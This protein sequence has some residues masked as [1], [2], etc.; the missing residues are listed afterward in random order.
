MAAMD[1]LDDIPRHWAA[2]RGDAI[3][4]RDEAGPRTWAALDDARESLATQIADLGVR[5]GDR[6]VIV[7]ESCAQM[8]A[9]LFALASVD[10]WIVNLN[11]RLTA[12]EVDAIRAHAGARCMLFLPDN[13][14]DAATHAA[15]H[16]A[17]PVAGCGWGS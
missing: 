17:R 13:S 9:L 6:V 3:V 1:R 15:R 11:A 12:R 4:L 10:A 2:Q 8:V 5:A 16:G 7:G 14:P